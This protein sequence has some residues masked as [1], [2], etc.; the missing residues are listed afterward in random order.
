[1]DKKPLKP[2]AHGIMDYAVSGALMAAPYLLGMNRKAANTYAGIG[3]GYS[4]VNAFTDTGAGIK[5]LIPFSTTHKKADV[6]MLAGI[7]LLSLVSYIRKD[8]TAFRFHL[9]LLAVAALQ[10]V[11]TDFEAGS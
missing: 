6:G 3:A 7:G 5:K 11:I 8:E 9:G 4:L 2:T 10:F 1:M